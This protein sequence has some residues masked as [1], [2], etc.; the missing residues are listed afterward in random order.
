MQCIGVC[1]GV[2]ISRTGGALLGGVGGCGLAYSVGESGGDEVGDGDDPGAVVF[3]LAELIEAEELDPDE[4]YSLVGKALRNGGMLT[5]GT[6][7]KKLL[8][9][10]S[11]LGRDM[12]QDEVWARLNER[13]SAFVD[14][15]STS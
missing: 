15:F 3:F 12:N 2:R 9:T 6:V 8:P 7:A 10:T 11:S 13:L 5:P 4:T 14:R 1:G